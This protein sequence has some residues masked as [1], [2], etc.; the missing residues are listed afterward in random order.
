MLPTTTSAPNSPGRSQQGER[1]NIRCDHGQRA[2][3]V[4][5]FDEFRI[6]VN[7]AVGR[8][9]LH[10][11][12]EYRVVEFKP[13]VIVD[14]DVDTERVRARPDDLNRLRMTIVR[15]EKCFSIGHAGVAKRH[16]FRRGSGFV[17]HRSVGD[18]H[19]R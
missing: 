9:I 7:R 1:K 12:A 14:P 10:Q 11:R 15:D 8:G 3:I 17:E 6:I 13:R 5:L 19:A 4:R 18:L 16:R 2:R